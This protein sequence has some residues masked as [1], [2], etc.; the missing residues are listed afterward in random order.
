MIT[1]DLILQIEKDTSEKEGYFDF[2][3]D[4]EHMDD[5]HIQANRDGIKLFAS[6]L[7]RIAYDINP[8]RNKNN[9]ELFDINNNLFFDTQGMHIFYVHMIDK[10]KSEISKKDFEYKETWKDKLVG[11]IFISLFFFMVICSFIGAFKVI[12]WVFS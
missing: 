3:F 8:P 1:E 9:P 11:N 10:G 6:M 7:L 2:C 4:Q 5:E 12:Q